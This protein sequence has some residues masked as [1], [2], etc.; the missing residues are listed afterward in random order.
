MID[1]SAF[2]HER[3]Q[4]DASVRIGARS[5]VWQ[6]ATVIRG[7]IIGDDCNL[8][9]GACIDGSVVDHGSIICHNVAAGPGFYIGRRCFIGPNVTLCNDVWPTASKGGWS[10]EPFE[11]GRFAIVIEDGASVGANSVILPGVRIGA[12]AMIAAG[13]VV[14]R[15]VPPF[16]LFGGGRVRLIDRSPK[17]M[18]FAA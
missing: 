17:R 3:A 6:F 5:R 1:G 18:R 14:S 16:H 8:A 9:S 10:A 11:S 4:V 2:V 13:S 15:D 12:G 7:A